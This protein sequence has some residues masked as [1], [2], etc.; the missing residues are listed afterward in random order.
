MGFDSLDEGDRDDAQYHKDFHH[1]KADVDDVEY[2]L[3][4]Q[5]SKCSHTAG[6]RCGAWNKRHSGF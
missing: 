5:V 2:F 4:T 3:L 1:E 6:Q